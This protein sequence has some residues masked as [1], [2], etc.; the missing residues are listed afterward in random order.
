MNI[1]KGFWFMRTLFVKCFY[2]SIG[3]HS[4]I[5]KPVYIQNPKKIF[6][7]DKVRIY[8]G[9]RAELVENSASI[10]IGDNTSIGQNFHIVS[11][12]NELL[13]GK[14][15]TIS[16]NVFISDVDHTYS[17]TGVHVLDQK[18]RYRSTEIGEN[19]FIGYGAV[20][21][22]GTKLGKQCIVGANA[23][24]KGEFPDYCVIIG[25]PAKI[26]KIYNSETQKWEKVERKH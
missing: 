18:L 15:T 21:L 14:N 5:G 23:V 20:I 17:E 11:Y 8:P 26:V 7:G 4:Y 10:K 19:C 6:I 24:V 16:A 9:M 2:G 12:N 3:K 13:I 25:C 1:V 22:P